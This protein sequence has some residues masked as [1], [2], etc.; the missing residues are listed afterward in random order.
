MK[1]LSKAFKMV[2]VLVVA[3]MSFSGATIT[4]QA[5][6]PQG[7]QQRWEQR[8]DRNRDWQRDR[9][10][11]NDRDWERDRRDNR[12][13]GNWKDKYD[14]QKKKADSANKK[15]NWALGVAAV[16]AIIAIAK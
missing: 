13:D 4:A 14:D 10:R 6:G 3:L 1:T 9:N 15:A 2:L 8:D 12:D 16:A 7:P 5:A 11:D